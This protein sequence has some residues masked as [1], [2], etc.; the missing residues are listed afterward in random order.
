ME[1]PRRVHSATAIA[2]S[3]VTGTLLWANLR[4]TDMWIKVA[5]EPF[6]WLDLVAQRMFSRGW[7][8]APWMISLGGLRLHTSEAQ[9][10]GVLFLDGI[11]SDPASSPVSM[12]ARSACESEKSRSGNNDL[13]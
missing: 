13:K 6:E 7:P 10:Y 8:L 1:Y 5:Q 4:T 9:V 3:L 12:P 2:L 11:V